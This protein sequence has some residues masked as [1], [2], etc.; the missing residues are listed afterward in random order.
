MVRSQRAEF[1]CIDA[2]EFMCIHGLLLVHIE[3]FKDMAC[4]QIRC[5]S[6]VRRVRQCITVTGSSDGRK[7]IF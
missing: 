6:Y 4:S 1:M 2:S 5:V 7:N 3:A